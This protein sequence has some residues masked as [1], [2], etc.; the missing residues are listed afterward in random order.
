MILLFTVNGFLYC[1]PSDVF[2]AYYELGRYILILERDGVI[3]K[4]E[5]TKKSF[6]F[7]TNEVL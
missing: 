5:I 4:W 6:E 1:F 2:N 3:Q 7:V